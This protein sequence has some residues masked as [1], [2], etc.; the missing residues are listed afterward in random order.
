[1]VDGIEVLK[2]V[3]EV[4]PVLHFFRHEDADNLEKSDKNERCLADVNGLD[5]DGEMSQKSLEEALGDFQARVLGF[6]KA[7]EVVDDR[8]AVLLGLGALENPIEGVKHHT[9]DPVGRSAVRH[10]VVPE[11]A[12]QQGSAGLGGEAWRG[13]DDLAQQETFQFRVFGDA[14]GLVE[15]ALA[16]GPPLNK[17]A[18]PLGCPG[19]VGFPVEKHQEVLVAHTLAFGAELGL[20]IGQEGLGSGIFIRIGH[21]N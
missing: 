2:V 20:E 1:M 18:E 14:E 4:D 12:D 11:A 3:D 21:G 8:D 5:L 16:F 19:D 17:V 13:D 10:V 7:P 15:D 9:D 6:F